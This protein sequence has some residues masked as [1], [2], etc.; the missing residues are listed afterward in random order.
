[1]DIQV[2]S[3]FE[4]LLFDLNG[5]DGLALAEQM[6]GFEATKA[7]QLTNAQAQGASALFSSARA[8][9]DDMMRA[10]R[11]AWENCGEQIDP[12]TACGLHG[13]QQSGIDA[14]VPVVTLATAHPAKF[15]DPVERA[16]GSRP[17]LPVRVGDLFER[18]ERYVEL[19]GEYDAVAEYVA[20]R[21][22]PKG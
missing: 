21:A 17:A 14:S 2:S 8:D 11:W 12:H 6:A 1:M 10:M 20:D 3:N 5:R 4:R 16:T 18:E 19:P 15:P 7:M 13:A 9:S 22:T